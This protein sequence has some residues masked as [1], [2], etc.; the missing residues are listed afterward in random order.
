M[1]SQRSG[2][3]VS[4]RVTHLREYHE[5]AN[6]FVNFINDMIRSGWIV[7]GNEFPDFVEV[8]EGLRVE[9]KAAH[10]RW[11]SLLF[12]RRRL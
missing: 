6:R 1:E 7:I 12:L 8:C 10:E 3:K 4:T 11:E 5:V 9:D 2:C